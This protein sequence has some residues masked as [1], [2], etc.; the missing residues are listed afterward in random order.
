MAKS[1][2]WKNKKVL[3]T[4]G[5]GFLGTH[6]IAELKS[7]G[8]TNIEVPE[9]PKIDLTKL[10]DCQKV[11]KGKDIVIHLA[12]KVGGIGYNQEHPAELF[13]DNLMM[14][15]Q[16]MHEA[17]KAG[18]KKYVT[19]ATICSYPKFTPVPFKESSLWQGY[20]EE[21]N[22][23]YGLAKLMQLV[24]SQSYRQQYGFNSIV[25]FPINLY[26]PNDNFDPKSSHVIPA[27]I[28][29][30]YDAKKAN[31]DHIVLWGTGKATRGFL[32]VKDAAQGIAEAVE[33]YNK[34]DPINLGMPIE[35]AIRDLAKM[36]MKIMDYKGKIV[37]DKSRPDGQPRRGLNISRAKK[38]FGFITKTD[39]RQG[40]KETIDWYVGR[41]EK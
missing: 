35:I 23:P 22:A 34:S 7:R 18:V 10:E 32:Y 11:V 8:V 13:Y 15:T 38:E 20:P 40:L 27:L 19:L 28:K 3:V 9:Y 30:V 1:A 24:Q 33:K 36:I 12:A 31:A 2:F 14:S 25:L 41:Q 37:Y 17:Q 5:K 16:L 6:L 39:F 4:G 26:G 21:T 29:K